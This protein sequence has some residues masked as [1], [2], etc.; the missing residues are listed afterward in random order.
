MIS[1]V[2]ESL[3]DAFFYLGLA[4]VLATLFVPFLISRRKKLFFEVVYEAKLLGSEGNDPEPATETNDVAGPMLFVID[5][6]NVPGGLSGGLLGTVDIAPAQYQREISLG[7]GEKTH[8]LEA[9]VLESPHDMEAKVLTDRSQEERLVLEPVA[10]ERGGLIRVKAVVKN[11]KPEPDPFWVG[12]GVRYIVEVDGRIVGVRQIQRKWESQKLMVSA[13]LAGA[14]GV[15]LDYSVVGWIRSLLAEDRT[16]LLAPP[17]FLLG[18]QLAFV[19]IAA[20]LLILALYK[21]R[22]SREM[23]GQLRSSYPRA[24]RKPRMGW[25]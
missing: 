12:G 2:L 10:L 4:V 13:F 18:A 20:V 23:A 16:W 7:F 15:I 14:L 25:P 24:E 17:A 6:H 5:L 11:P 21:D 3:N 1:F 19:G 9:E 22:R 8:I